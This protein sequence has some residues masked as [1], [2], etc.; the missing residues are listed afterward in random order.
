MAEESVLISEKL[1][2]SE[3]EAELSAHLQPAQDNSTSTKQ[4]SMIL[5]LQVLVYILHVLLVPCLVFFA[6]LQ[7]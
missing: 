5:A 6:K 7:P 4:Q 3:P 1:T 2:Q